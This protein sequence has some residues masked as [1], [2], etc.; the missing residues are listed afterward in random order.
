MNEANS[1]LRT[2]VSKSPIFCKKAVQDQTADISAEVNILGV[3]HQ[4]R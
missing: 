2:W 4:R 3:F 1:N